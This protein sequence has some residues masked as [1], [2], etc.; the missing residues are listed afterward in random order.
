MQNL[1]K[2]ISFSIFSELKI[3][4]FSGHLTWAASLTLLKVSLFSKDWLTYSGGTNKY[5]EHCYVFFSILN[6]L[7]QIV[8]FPIWTPDFDS[9]TRDPLHLCLSADT[10]ICSTVTFHALGNSDHVVVSVSIDI[11]SDSK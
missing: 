10:S 4:L 8:N 5:G 6:D 2:G 9:H 11:L 1:L 3:S 7:T